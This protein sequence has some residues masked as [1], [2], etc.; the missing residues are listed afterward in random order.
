MTQGHISLSE[1]PFLELLYLKSEEVNPPIMD[2]SNFC[3]I[4][5][6]NSSHDF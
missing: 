1:R 5:L 3:V 2:I 4:T 6:L